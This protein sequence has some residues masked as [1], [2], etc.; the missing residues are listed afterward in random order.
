LAIAAAVAAFV[1]ILSPGLAISGLIAILA[2]IACGIGL[3]VDMRRSREPRAW[4]AKRERRS[5]LQR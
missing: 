1:L 3:L 4:S 5:R 2:L